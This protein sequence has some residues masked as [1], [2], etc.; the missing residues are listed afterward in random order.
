MI[1]ATPESI[2]ETAVDSPKQAQ[3]NGTVK[4]TAGFLNK[5]INDQ[6]SPN[7]EDQLFL[8]LQNTELDEFN[9]W[10]KWAYAESL[11]K[12]APQIGSVQRLGS[13]S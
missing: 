12:A 7:P 4:N 3:K 13:I 2:I 5:V 8:N 10:W 9:A 6:W 11:V 1:D